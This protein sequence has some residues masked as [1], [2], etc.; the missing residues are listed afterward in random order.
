MTPDS[1]NK[2]QLHRVKTKTVKYCGKS[3]VLIL[4]FTYTF[5]IHFLT[6]SLVFDSSNLNNYIYIVERSRYFGCSGSQK[7]VGLDIAILTHRL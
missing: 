1:M 4:C 7:S 5:V 3:A 2:H 6:L